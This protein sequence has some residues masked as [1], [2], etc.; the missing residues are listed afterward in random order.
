MVKR[1]VGLTL[2][3]SFGGLSVIVLAAPGV[4][5]YLKIITLRVW[6]QQ[7][8]GCIHPRLFS[9]FLSK[10]KYLSNCAFWRPASFD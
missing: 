9:R 10:F 2:G 5:A 3:F 1:G 4:E 7:Y 8:T 6:A